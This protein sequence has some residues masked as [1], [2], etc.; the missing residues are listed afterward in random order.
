MGVRLPAVVAEEVWLF[1]MLG[2]K[3]YPSSPRQQEKCAGPDATEPWLGIGLWTI[4]HVK[5]CPPRLK[6]AHFMLLRAAGPCHCLIPRVASLRM[7]M[8][9]Y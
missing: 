7:E 3:W 4:L 6:Q 8:K 9:R 5:W 1:K 2:N